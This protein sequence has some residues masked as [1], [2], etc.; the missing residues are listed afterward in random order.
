MPS[1]AS[2]REYGD[3]QHIVA[4]VEVDHPAYQRIRGFKSV[5]N[6]VPYFDT[7]NKG[8]QIGADFYFNY[9]KTSTYYDVRTR[10]EALL[11]VEIERL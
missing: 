2:L 5:V 7:K 6:V 4:Y 1:D 9:R 11:G 10:L 8:K 3:G